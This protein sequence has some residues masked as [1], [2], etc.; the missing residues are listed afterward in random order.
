ML[1]ASM[2]IEFTKYKK[3]SILSSMNNLESGQARL[4][5]LLRRRQGGSY[6]RIIRIGTKERISLF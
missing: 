1:L 5:D 4:R 6:G 3:Y 2:K